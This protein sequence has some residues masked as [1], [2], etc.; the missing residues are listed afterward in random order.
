MSANPTN[1]SKTTVNGFKGR[2]DG[3][4][5]RR[6]LS[7]WLCLLLAAVAAAAIDA[8]G[9]GL[10]VPPQPGPFWA[11]AAVLAGLQLLLAEGVRRLAPQVGVTTASR[12]LWAA[13]ITAVGFAIET[14]LRLF[15]GSPYLLDS[16]L[17]TL[18]RNAMIGL[19][20]LAHH[21]SAQAPAVVLAT[22]LMVFAAA[23]FAGSSHTLPWCHG[24]LVTFTLLAMGWLINRHWEGL[25]ASLAATAIRRQRPWWTPALALLV[26]LPLLIPASGGRLVATEG[27][28]PTSG[29]GGD[30]SS[31][32]RDGIGDGDLL[33]AG[34][35]NIRSFAPIENAPFATSHEPTLYDVFDDTYNEPTFDKKKRQRAIGLEPQIRALAEDHR[36]ARSAKAAREFSTVRRPG[37]RSRQPIGSLESNAVMYVRGRLPLHLKLESFDIYDGDRWVAEPP[38]DG[39]PPLTLET[40]AERPWLRLGVA[41]KRRDPHAAPELHALKVINLDTNRVPTP[42]QLTGVSLDKLNRANFFRWEQPG[43]V[44]VDRDRL[45]ELTTLHVQSR[46]VDRRRLDPQTDFSAGPLRYRQIDDGP[47]SLRVRS[48][49]ER[50]VAGVPRGWPQVEAIVS[51]LRQDYQLD[52]EARASGGTGHSI[53]EFLFE[54]HQGPDYLFASAAV[55]LLRSLDYPARFVTGFYASP[56][57]YDARSGHAA[58]LPEDIHCWAEL[59]LGDGVWIS[60]EPTPGYDLLSPPLTLTEQ[61]F[62]TIGF[63]W[64][65]ACNRPLLSFS[66][67]ATLVLLVRFR[68][69]LTDAVDVALLRMRP[70]GQGTSLTRQTF[71]TLDRRCRR[72]GLARPSAIPPRRW[73]EGLAAEIAAN[74]LPQNQSPTRP[75]A[76]EQFLVGLD[77][78][79]YAPPGQPP[80]DTPVCWSALGLWS[81]RNLAL[82]R[83][84]PEATA[85]LTA[86]SPHRRRPTCSLH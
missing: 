73:F 53:A 43:I 5:P 71:K 35:D 84:H 44:G 69:R 57:R 61:F 79:L 47:S 46:V 54:T 42:N 36:M 26:A 38:P 76:V 15:L 28:L 3:Q 32:A 29:G 19:A 58:V 37:A 2:A 68:R 30:A 50:W 9:F 74:G 56:T 59:R 16:L 51:R 82:I 34:L 24:L 12:R 86:R 33:V 8:A 85:V 80:A 49:A 60:L 6:S 52:P 63:A 45:P 67:L 55:W 72:V 70:T 7:G 14:S 23:C 18:L 62:A 25:E 65:T 78:C 20:A 77:R 17:L 31:M 66:L 48:L 27:W 11:T 83:R 81:W 13:A 41:A 22:F 21:R 4:P 75:D 39:P 40:I 10:V 1:Q 64:Q